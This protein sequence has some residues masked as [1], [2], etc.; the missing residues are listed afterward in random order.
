MAAESIIS[1]SIIS[2]LIINA[3]PHPLR[4]TPVQAV[5]PAGMS[6][7]EIV[8]AAHERVHIVLD[9]EYMPRER[10]PEV[11]PHAG[12]VVEVRAVPAGGDNFWRVVGTILIAAAAFYVPTLWSLQGTFGG[13]MLAAGVTLAGTLALNALLPPPTPSATDFGSGSRGQSL[14]GIR[15]GMAPYGLVPRPYGRMQV[16]PLVVGKPVTEII[17]NDQYLRMLFVVGVG[18]FN[19]AELRIGDALVSSFSDIQINVGAATLDQTYGG[20]ATN[21]NPQSLYGRDVNET[22]LSDTLTSKTGPVTVTRTT[23]ID[24]V[25]FGVDLTMPQ[26]LLFQHSGGDKYAIGILL[27]IEYAPAGSGS[28]INLAG[29]AGLKLSSA[30][31]RP[32]I[33]PSGVRFFVNGW[34]ADTLRA[35]LS[36]PVAQGQYDIRITPEGAYTHKPHG[37]RHQFNSNCDNEVPTTC[38]T[39]LGKYGHLWSYGLADVTLFDDLLPHPW[40]LPNMPANLVDIQWTALRTWQPGLPVD[41]ALASNA[42]LIGMRIRATDQLNG[43][44]DQFNLIAEARLS[45]WNGSSWAAAA[46]TRNPAWAYVNALTGTAN[47]RPVALSRINTTEIKAWGDWCAANGF[48]YDSRGDGDMTVFELIREITAAG[49]ATWAIRDGLYTVVRDTESLTPV[50]M[51]T[52]RN[53]WGF[54][55]TKAFPD[56]PHALKVRYINPAANYV[57]DEAV[58]YA[59]GYSKA[60]AGGTAV[61][62]RFED[63]PLPGVAD[64]SQAW[65][66]GRYHLAQLKLRPEVYTLNVDIENMACSRG[67]LVRCAHDVTLWGAGWGRI[68]SVTGSPATAFTTDET[69]VMDG[70]STYVVRVRR[71]D[72]TQVVQQVATVIGNTNTLTP[73]APVSGIAEGDLVILGIQGNESADL[74]IIRIEPGADLTAKLTLVD[75]APNIHQAGQGV[76]PAY[77]SHITQPLALD[78]IPPPV[79]QVIRIRSNESVL[80]PG[81]DGTLRVRVVV[82]Y[83]FAVTVGLP[84]LLVEMRLRRANGHDQWQSVAARSAGLGQIDAFDVEELA[85]YELQLRAVNGALVSA[86][87]AVQSHTIIGKSTPPGDA[88]SFVAM[89]NGDV[90]HLSWTL[91]P[92]PDIGGVEIRRQ[93]PGVLTWNTAQPVVITGKVNNIATANIPPGHWT[94]LLKA[95]DTYTHPNYSA[96]AI[97]DAIEMVNT[98]DVIDARSWAPD[99]NGTL[100]GCLRHWSGVLIPLDQFLA[101]AYGWE[102]FDSAVPNPV[103]T[104]TYESPEVDIGIDNTVRLWGAVESALLPGETAAMTPVV[105]MD[106]RLAAGAYDG[107]EPWDIGNRAGRY[108]KWRLTLDNSQGARRVTAFNVTLDLAERSEVWESLTVAVGGTPITFTTPFHRIPHLS[109]QIYNTTTEVRFDNVTK[110]GNVYTGATVYIYNSSSNTSVGGIAAKIKATGV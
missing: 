61:A 35:G 81:A 47:P 13:A 66:L 79:P 104:S 22:A 91:P 67:S 62:T 32:F 8:G 29:G 54:G 15:N 92:D 88:S 25:E 87:S 77:E 49:R 51:F 84:G 64:Y 101:S 103:A 78:R 110:V 19:L 36:L 27:K 80:V 30:N 24:C 43:I 58:V 94:L 18:Q 11:R 7:A 83:K 89:Q 105:S 5:A 26:G 38:E 63:L 70:I 37:W 68:K 55:A 86:W 90:A 82:Y 28:W 1:E 97:S 14:T 12:Q 10:W 107:F 16:Y 20:I 69:L 60:G 73:T 56:H 57:E 85:G 42:V 75:A 53:S 17:G 72:G 4:Q 99:W 93:P 23:A 106:S 41:A 39:E 109:G 71:S 9:G 6:L 95:F 76:I 98:S 108:F 102:L 3:Y 52:P 2:G 96:N 33:T 50:Q 44:V 48:Y 100:T 21:G 74:K 31:I 45:A 46:V 34:T 65:K 59:D 40:D